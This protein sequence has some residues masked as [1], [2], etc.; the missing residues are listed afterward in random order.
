MAYPVVCSPPVER[1][2]SPTAPQG[3]LPVLSAHTHPI[4]LINRAAEMGF[5]GMT[6][7]FLD[8]LLKERGIR[9]RRRTMA[10]RV[11]ALLRDIF[12][13]ISDQRI[14]EILMKRLPVVQSKPVDSS[15][16]PDGVLEASDK[17]ELV[18]AAGQYERSKAEAEKLRE[19]LLPGSKF[20][21]GCADAPAAKKAEGP[22][23]KRGNRTAAECATV[24]SVEAARKYLPDIKGCTVQRIPDRRT[25]IVFYPGVSPASRSRR[26]GFL[27]PESKVVRHVLAWA[28][29]HH[30]EIE[31][32]RCPW[33]FV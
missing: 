25:W 14:H 16:V 23:A 27:Q 31:G 28:W 15:L 22:V 20:L 5:V 9:D 13:D 2:G 32:V 33:N 10:A 19:M 21:S 8:R 30:E 12:P 17:Q 29:K 7:L 3:V 6:S 18:Q 4:P 1:L 24:R 26:W 11:V